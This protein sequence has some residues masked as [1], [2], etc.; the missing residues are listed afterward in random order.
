MG[1]V[2]RCILKQDGKSNNICLKT[3]F[4]QK[5]RD[6][7]KHIILNTIKIEIDFGINCYKRDMLVIRHH[8]TI[9]T[10]NQQLK[11]KNTRVDNSFSTR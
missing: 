5:Y 6:K 3:E 7:I 11:M 10:V 9:I 4:Y 8:F 2:K 1:H